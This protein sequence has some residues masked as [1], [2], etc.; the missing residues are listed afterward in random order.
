M[1]APQSFASHQKRNPD[2]PT[3][4]SYN[5]ASS[6]CDFPTNGKKK[7]TT[8][9]ENQKSFLVYMIYG[10]ILHNVN[11]PFIRFR[12]TPMKFN[13]VMLLDLKNLAHTWNPHN[14]FELKKCLLLF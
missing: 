6:C 5:N 10:I 3:T 13:D 2:S 14:F 11:P 7:Q 8:S 1:K 9:S 4:G 12:N